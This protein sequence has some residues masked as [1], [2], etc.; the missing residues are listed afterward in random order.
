MSR[1]A[2]TPLSIE[3]VKLVM[4]QRLGDA[5]GFLSRLFCA[6]ELASIGW[7]GPIA[8]INHTYTAQRGTCRGMHF[9]RGP[10]TETK[11]VTCLRGVVWDVAVDLRPASQTFLKWSAA[12]LNAQTGGALLIP[13]GF[14]HGFQ[15]L[16]DDV[17]L[18]YCHDQFYHPES[19]GGLHPQDPQLK[20]DWPLPVIG[21]SPRDQ[22]HPLMDAGFKGAE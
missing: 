20:M 14:A 18:L 3:E 19:E 22:S 16:S 6:E 5:R 2:I 15:T 17:E 8:Q 12:E 13:A 1:F 10:H 9:Q 21:L 4:R 11:L 7:R